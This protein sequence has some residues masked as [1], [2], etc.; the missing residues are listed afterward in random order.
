MT[1]DLSALRRDYSRRP[2]NESDCDADPL[3]QFQ[4]WLDE[5]LSVDGMIE[6][7]AMS[8]ATA[9]REGV[10]SVRMVLLKGFDERGFRFFTNYE[11]RKAAELEANPRAALC[12]WWGALERQVR[13][14]GTIERTTTEESDE[15]FHSRPWYSQIGA[16][17]SR[18]SHPIARREELE[19]R[20]LA[21]VARHANQ[22]VP[23]PDTWGGYRVWPSR[24]EFWQGRESR[25]HD[26]IVYEREAESWRIT[27]LQP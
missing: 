26:R 3:R 2:L 7:N 6:P 19:Q 11:S 25:L 12:I 9:T 13:I 1:T 20:T 16:A 21:L 15:Y 22:K 4:K 18:Q 23:R 27:R 24:I 8:L 14:E 10:P 5:A 17:A